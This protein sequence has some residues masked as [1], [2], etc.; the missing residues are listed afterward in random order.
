MARTNPALTAKEWAA[1]AAKIDRSPTLDDVSVTLDGRRLD[2]KEKVLA[3]LTEIE[4][5]V[6]AGRTVLTP[7]P[8]SL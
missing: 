1:A 6:A 8:D 7:S 4:A 2:F 3:F 5:D